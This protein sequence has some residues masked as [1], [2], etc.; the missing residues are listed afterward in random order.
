MIP[1]LMSLNSVNF[2]FRQCVF[3]DD[4]LNVKDKKGDSRDGSGR[5]VMFKETGCNPF[6]YTFEAN[7]ATGH[8]INTLA[9]RFDI[10][11]DKKLIKEDSPIQ[12]TSSSLYSGGKVPIFTPEIFADVGQSVLIALLDYDRINPISRLI[13]KK[14]DT[15][16]AAIEKLIEDMKKSD[17]KPSITS[18]KKKL[19]VGK[20]KK[21]ASKIDNFEIVENPKQK[22]KS[23]KE[24]EKKEVK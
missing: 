1:K 13:K 9:P 8:R 15:L 4:K 2:D 12:D 17:E 7:Y 23:P 16:D 10:E 22:Q 11:K 24:E 14:G 21:F 19:G 6:V 20:K 18:I 3:S 5:A